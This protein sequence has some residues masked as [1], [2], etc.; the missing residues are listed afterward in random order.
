LLSVDHAPRPQ[1]AA[2]PVILEVINLS[3]HGVFRDI[4]F[5]VRAGEIVGMAGLV[6]AGRSEVARVI[7]GADKADSGE[8]RVSGAPLRG[9]SV[10]EAI[11][12]GIGMVPEDRQHLGLVLQLPV[13]VNL[14]L[15]ELGSLTTMGLI[16]S[17]KER[18]LVATMIKEL[19]V[20]AANPSVA[21]QTLSGGNQQK[22]VA[23]KWLASRP[24]VLILDEPTRGVDVGAKAEMHKLIRKLADAGNTATLLISSDL[25]EV[26]ALS[27]RILVMRGG[28][29]A[30][31][32]SRA[33]ATQEKVLALAIPGG[34]AA[35]TGGAGA[36]A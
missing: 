28:Q 3:R 10:R 32:L 9:G 5:N 21:A 36:A 6:G 15:T 23:G 1:L 22:L 8:V 29:I 14:S 30:G 27:D 13:S 18:A 2:G 31:E 12:R 11:D 26:L 25:P 4:S 17:R 34:N 16:S 7:F 19:Q 33:E 24:R 20:K 35:A